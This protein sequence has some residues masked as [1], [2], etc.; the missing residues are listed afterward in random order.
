MKQTR[1]EIITEAHTTMIDPD[2][3]RGCAKFQ[4]LSQFLYT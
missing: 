2:S 1:S 4:V 3:Y